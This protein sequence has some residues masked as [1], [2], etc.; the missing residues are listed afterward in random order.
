MFD[1]HRVEL[2]WGGR[3]LTLETG[4]VARQA[5]GAVLATYGETTVLAAVVAAKQPKEGIDFLPLNVNYTEKYYAAGRI[6]GGYFKRERGPTEKDTLTSRL[7]DRPVRPLFADGWR[8]ETQV[9]VTVLSHDLENDPDILAMVAASAALTL[10]G[11]PFMGPI[12]AARVAFIN[13]E[14]V[15]NPQI[16]E[17]ADSALEL[18]VAGTADAVLM[19]ESEAKELSE[20]I[21]L[22]AVMFGQKHFQ[23]VLD[24]IVKLAERAAKEPW[25]LKV[26]TSGE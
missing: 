21:M 9:I 19:V 18:V 15:L 10:S 22:G 23:P 12:G 4:R 26:D 24:A 2:D 6:P 17:M 3:K 13:N 16:D 11:A 8:C 1:M 14:F 20:D 5:D 25:E 7:I